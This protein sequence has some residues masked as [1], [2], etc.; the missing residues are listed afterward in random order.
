[1][2]TASVENALRA[3]FE[4][5][6]PAS[7]R[8]YKEAR[9]IFPDGVT[10]DSRHLRPFP[11]Y[12]TQ[13]RGAHKWDLDG[14]ELIDYW[15]GQGALLLG[16]NHPLVIQAAQD[17]L[18]RGTQF[19]ASHELK[20]D[21]GR[22]VQRLIPSAE[23]ARFVSLATEATLLAIR[24]AR[25]FTGKYGLIRFAGHFHGWH[26]TVAH[27]YQPPFD[28][29]VSPG[30]PPGVLD[31]VICLPPNDLAIVE[32]TMNSRRDIAAVILEPAGGANA[33]IPTRPGHLGGLRDLCQRHQAILIFDEVISG[34]RYAP[35]GA[36]EFFGVIPDL[37]VL[38]KI[39]AGGLPGGAVAGRAELLAAMEFQHE[40]DRNPRGRVMHMGTFNANPLSAA[41]GIAALSP[42]ASGEAQ[43]QA[44]RLTM[45]LI[46]GMNDVLR[47]HQISGCV[48]GDPAAFHLLLGQRDIGP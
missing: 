7:L 46:A 16:H 22:W 15:M 35:G 13:A 23:R 8:R 42:A 40:L 48:Y 3:E 20:L 31:D 36:Q 39:L 24:L 25:A 33:W 38:A 30:I 1:M 28:I 29:P 45:G 27:G 11:V 12:I 17:Q 21:W 43:T 37:T 47:S 6:F 41:A 2:L 9:R 32:R 10:H 19:G 5:R 18:Q 14:N 34:F 44:G 4:A 26:D